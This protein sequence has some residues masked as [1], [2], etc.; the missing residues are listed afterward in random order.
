MLGPKDTPAPAHVRLD[1]DAAR[2]FADDLNQ[3]VIGKAYTW[4]AAHPEHEP[5]RSMS[6]PES[7]PLVMACAGGS[8]G[9]DAMNRPPE[10]HTP[11]RLRRTDWQS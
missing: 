10:P 8:A 5:F 11:M 3:R 9:E 2:E 6:I 1:D 4:V 7:G